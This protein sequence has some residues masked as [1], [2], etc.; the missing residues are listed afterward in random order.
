MKDYKDLVYPEDENKRTKLL[1][2]Y[3]HKFEKS[4]ERKRKMKSADDEGEEIDEE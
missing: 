2:Y 4:E 3:L 1:N